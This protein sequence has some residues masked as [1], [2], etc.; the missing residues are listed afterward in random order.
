MLWCLRSWSVRVIAQN[1]AYVAAGAAS[2]VTPKLWC[3][4]SWSSDIHALPV[5]PVTLLLA[6]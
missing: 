3:L 2:I 5:L 4:R 1:H 6:G